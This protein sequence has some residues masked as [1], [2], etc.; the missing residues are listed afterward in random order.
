MYILIHVVSQTLANMAKK[1]LSREGIY[2]TVK[3]SPPS[4]SKT[5]C[6][7]CL[8]VNSRELSRALTVLRDNNIKYLG[9]YEVDG[10]SV[11][12]V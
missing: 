2:T 9:L 10:E 11:R 12:R 4:V 6:G 7:Y 8:K 3:K 1:L 5:G